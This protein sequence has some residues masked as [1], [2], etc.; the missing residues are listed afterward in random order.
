VRPVPALDF[1][2]Q[3]IPLAWDW[4]ET[5][6]ADV[7]EAQANWWPAGT[8]N[9]IAATYLHVVI[10]PDVEIHRL[11]FGD[12]PILESHWLGD[13]GQAISYDPDRFDDWIRGVE[14]PWERL[15]EYGRAVHAWLVGSLHTL[16]DEDLIRPVDMT[17]AGL[18]VWTGWDLYGLHGWRHVYMHG[19][20][21]ACLKGLQGAKGYTS[22]FDAPDGPQ[23]D[24]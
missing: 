16:T 18:G 24:V 15:H 22:G 12:V 14:V 8:A 3:E 2:R 7:T 5:V 23:K 10:N 19:G 1:L 11:L 21:I 4:L 9:S 6:V 20:E 13:L 17:Q